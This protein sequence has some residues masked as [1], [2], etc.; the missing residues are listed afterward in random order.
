MNINI[1]STSSKTDNRKAYKSNLNRAEDKSSFKKNVQKFVRKLK[2]EQNIRI[3]TSDNNDLKLAFAESVR[4]FRNNNLFNT[5]MIVFLVL[6]DLNGVRKNVSFKH[7]GQTSSQLVDKILG[8]V[9]AESDASDANEYINSQFI[10]VIFEIQFWDRVENDLG[11]E[12]D[13]NMYNR[14]DWEFGSI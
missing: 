6:K 11:D 1:D 9:T 4:A 2:Q 7:E 14:C 10:P 12:I 5:D 13:M 3:D 8:E